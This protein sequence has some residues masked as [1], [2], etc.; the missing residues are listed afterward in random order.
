MNNKNQV[1]AEVEIRYR[2]DIYLL[3]VQALEIQK[4]K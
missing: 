4:N 2:K 3:Q 1:E